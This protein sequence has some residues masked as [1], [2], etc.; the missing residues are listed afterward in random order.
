[1]AGDRKRAKK[2]PLCGA[3]AAAAH[4]PF[5]SARCR[6]LDLANWLGGNYRVPVV[7]EDSGLEEAED[8][9]DT[10]SRVLN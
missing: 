2:C 5:C 9:P 7:E 4:A 8:E 1:M 6:D 3:P 10:R